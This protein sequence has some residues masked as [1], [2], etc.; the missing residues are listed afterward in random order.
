MLGDSGQRQSGAA[1]NHYLLPID[2][3]PCSADLP[4]LQLRPRVPARTLSTIK[5]FSHSA[6]APMMAINAQRPASVDVF[7]E[8]D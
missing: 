7:S 5:D 1:V 3:Q 4:P 6:I 8:G 2:V